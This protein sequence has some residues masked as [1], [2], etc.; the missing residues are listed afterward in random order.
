[1]VPILILCNRLTT[2]LK[3][4]L[5]EPKV[6][7]PNERL[8]YI[9]KDKT[10]ACGYFVDSDQAVLPTVNFCNI[11]GKP[12]GHYCSTVTLKALANT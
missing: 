4:A 5:S 12:A 7:R 6:Q 2:G 8:R 3:L 9:C 11:L 1:M 10:A